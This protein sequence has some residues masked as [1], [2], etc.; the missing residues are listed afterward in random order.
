MTMC[1]FTA[2]LQGR[3]TD[4]QQKCEHTSSAS[5]LELPFHLAGFTPRKRSII[6]K[7]VPDAVALVP[8]R[9]VDT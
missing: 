2:R 5:L 9:L 8:A 1:M 3:E 6:P 4:V 7:L